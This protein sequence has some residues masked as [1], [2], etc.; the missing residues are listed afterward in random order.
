[1]SVIPRVKSILIW[2]E[3]E[4][5]IRIGFIIKEWQKKAIRE[6]YE[7]MYPREEGSTWY[8]NSKYEGMAEG[9]EIESKKRRRTGHKSG[10]KRWCCDRNV[11]NC[12]RYSIVD[13]EEAEEDKVDFG[14]CFST[15][16][17]VL[18]DGEE[19]EETV[20]SSSWLYS[21]GIR[22]K[23]MKILRR[24]IPPDTIGG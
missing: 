3:W 16:F 7:N 2:I 13:V 24:N 4:V 23:H 19:E 12:R 17:S 5:R 18:L 11:Y 10:R 1:M 20:F 21:D 14:D 22:N 15:I 9:D 6:V 8:C